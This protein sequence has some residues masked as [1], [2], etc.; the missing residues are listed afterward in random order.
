[1]PMLLPCPVASR[2]KP[3]CSSNLFVCLVPVRAQVVL[4]VLL[5]GADAE[6]APEVR[7]VLLPEY[8]VVNPGR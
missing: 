7:G 2:K 6:A 1:M 8:L 3:P 5:V 4:E